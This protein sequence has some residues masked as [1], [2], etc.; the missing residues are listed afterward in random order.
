MGRGGSRETEIKAL[1]RFT[2][3]SLKLKTFMHFEKGKSIL[4]KM[5]TVWQMSL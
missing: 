5:Y 3:S 4:M 2:A 1:Q